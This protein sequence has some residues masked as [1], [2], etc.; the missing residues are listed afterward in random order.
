[1]D[2]TPTRIPPRSRR[3]LLLAAGWL[4]VGLGVIGAVLPLLPTTPF[5]LVAAA[6]FTGSS[7]RMRDRLLSCPYLRQYFENYR[8]GSGVPLRTKW[9]SLLFLWVTLGA[10]A[11]FKH[12]P[13]YWGILLL[14]GIAVSVHILMLKGQNPPVIKQSESE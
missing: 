8:S 11:L 1:M 10:S 14:V 7:P 4:C 5:L 3:L 2:K 13:Y 6:C 12:N 9:V